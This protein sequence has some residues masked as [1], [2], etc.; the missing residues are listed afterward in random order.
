MSSKLT[1]VSGRREVWSSWSSDFIS[2]ENFFKTF[3]FLNL[4]ETKNYIF[5]IFEQRK[6]Y[7]IHYKNKL[8]KRIDI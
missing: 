7:I 6:Y 5:F 4:K 1:S 2:V 3:L 8:N